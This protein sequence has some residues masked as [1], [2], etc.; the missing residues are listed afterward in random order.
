MRLVT[1]ISLMVIFLHFFAC[2]WFFITKFAPLYRTWLYFN[3]LQDESMAR[4]YLFS[5]YWAVTTL[6]TVGYGDIVAHNDSMISPGPKT[7]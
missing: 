2:M 6:S 5:L 1:F 4:Q 7:W 3:K